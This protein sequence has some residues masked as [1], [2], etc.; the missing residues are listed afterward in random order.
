MNHRD[1]VY[2]LAH[3]HDTY[4]WLIYTEPSIASDCIP[5]VLIIRKSYASRREVRIYEVKATESDLRQDVRNMKF[6]KYFDYA[7]RVYFAIGSDVPFKKAQEIL[8]GQQVGITQFNGEKWV[9]RKPA[10]RLAHTKS[11]DWPFFLALMMGSK[12]ITRNQNRLDRLESE[13]AKLISNSLPE[14]RRS[15]FRFLAHKADELE[16]LKSDLEYQKSRYESDLADMKKDAAREILKQLNVY[17]YVTDTPEAAERII[18]SAIKDP[19]KKAIHNLFSMKKKL[20]EIS[21]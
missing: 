7:D 9:M 17:N 12:E 19:L 8:S 2:N 1:L 3:N 10:P 16:K 14:L 15:A 4:D 5:D 6:Q 11:I 13:K 21:K 18:E 20:D